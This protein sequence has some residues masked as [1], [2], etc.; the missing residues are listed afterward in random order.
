M[1]DA[2]ILSTLKQSAPWVFKAVEMLGWHEETHDRE[3]TKLCWPATRD[4]RDLDSVIGRRHAWC[5]GFWCGIMEGLKL[6]HPRS[7]RA[8]SWQNWGE[9]CGFVFGAFLPLRHASGG[10][11]ICVFLWW[12]DQRNKIAA[13][14]G[15]N[16]GNRVSIAAYDLS[17]NDRG[18]ESV[19]SGP[20]WPFGYMP[21][22]EM[23]CQPPGWKVGTELG[24]STR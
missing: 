6:P 19:I 10:N 21:R 23:P 18:K 11:H 16:Q 4:C 2:S 24:A 15:G 17:G 1:I 22:S 14:L 8:S 13:C 3:L 9:P 20:R 5:S 7:G 12:I